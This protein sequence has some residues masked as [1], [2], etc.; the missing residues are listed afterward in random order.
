MPVI[1][2]LRCWLNEPVTAAR[3]E[4]LRP[5]VGRA[6]GKSVWLLSFPIIAIP[7]LIGLMVQGYWYIS[8]GFGLLSLPG[9]YLIG[10]EYKVYPRPGAQPKRGFADWYPDPDAPANRYRYWDGD[11]W[12]DRISTRAR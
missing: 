3:A 4:R 2:S 8:L 12:T 9:L 10:L 6:R 1:D 7:V 5:F 11:R